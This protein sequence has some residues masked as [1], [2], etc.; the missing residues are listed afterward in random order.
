MSIPLNAAQREAVATVDRPCLVLAG[1]GS[2][3]TRVITAKI[4]HLIESGYDA[5]EIGALTFT[6]KAAAEMKSRADSLL[7]ERNLSARGLGVST[8]HSLG[9]RLLRAEAEHLGLK[10]AFSIL[11]STD[12]AAIVQ[13]NLQTVDRKVV[14]AVTSR[15]S[16]WKSALVD[17]DHAAAEA[18]DEHEHQAAKVY[19]SYDATLRAYQAVDFDDLIGLPVKLFT[20]RHDRLLHWQARL[21]YLLVDEYQDTNASQYQLMKLLAGTR[22]A[23]TAVG[24]DDQSI[25]A[26]RGATVENI[27]QLERDFPRIAV[28]KLEQNYRS[29]QR[30]LAAA[31][32][33][34]AH[35][36]K[37][38]E[39][40]LWSEHGIGDAIALTAYEDDEDEA[41]GVVAKLTGLK[42]EKR[43]EWR[44][45][46][47]LY[48]SNQQARMFEQQL[49]NERIPYKMS[50]GQ[51]FFDKAEIRDLT[52]YLR[53][54]AN[55]DDDPAFIRAITT[56]KRGIGTATLES[57]GNYAGERRVSLFEAA[58][59]PGVHD[60]LGKKVDD[61]R[62]FGD[63]I[64]RLTF[65]AE[66]EKGQEAVG[67][68]MNDLLKHIGYEA[69]LFDQNDER[70]AQSKWQNVL[71]FVG[72]VGQRA[73]ED[74]FQPARS[75]LDVA[76]TLAIMS[77]IDRD[78]ADAD[79][80]RLS[81][82]H[83]AKGLEFPHVFLVGVE[84]GLL[85]H[86]GG[87]LEIPAARLEE[88]RRLMYVGIT[89]AQRS[90]HVGHCQARKRGRGKASA[91]VACLPSRFVAEM[92]LDSPMQVKADTEKRDPKAMLAG[93]K[94]ML[95]G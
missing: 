44:D 73:A 52:A 23:F 8:F 28:I 11:D 14:A 47:I 77:M 54:M 6:N 53:V 79:V 76:Q 92:G 17:P 82:L 75:L 80:V 95:A 65:R 15:I 33:L 26:W 49:R 1:A 32:S 56:P 21:R 37:L 83:A 69:H 62:E 72:W 31:N 51:S 12:A 29:S 16:N 45:F 25:Y 36:P 7:K 24:D 39:K 94:A 48:R 71:D 41:R 22:A 70:A 85:P 40:K 74:E 34:I 10:P 27:A 90:L 81:T 63:F 86:L 46:A 38:Y 55:G 87:A 19:R 57:L 13:E 89:R 59:L 93:L 78:E 66:R 67:V 3:K 50:G 42:Y 35:N 60:R 4:A 68:L 20:E 2:G 30:I 5:R 61:V 88:E 64:N 43:A 18:A 91:S 58:Y 9:V 84:E